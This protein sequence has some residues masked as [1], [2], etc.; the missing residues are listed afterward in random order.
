MNLFLNIFDDFILMSIIYIDWCMCKG[1]DKEEK[2]GVFGISSNRY[3]NRY[4]LSN[5]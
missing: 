1:I 4:L 3:I 5:N 2:L